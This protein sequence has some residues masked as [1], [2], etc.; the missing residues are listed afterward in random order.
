M[1]E[2]P[3]A[4]GDLDLAPPG[5]LPVSPGV[6]P[7]SPSMPPAWNSSPPVPDKVTPARWGQLEPRSDVVPASAVVSVADARSRDNA[8]SP[9]PEPKLGSSPGAPP[10]PRPIR[11]E[12]NAPA[13]LA[14]RPRWDPATATALPPQDAG[15]SS[16]WVSQLA[17]TPSPP[18]TSEVAADR[19]KPTPREAVPAGRDSVVSRFVRRVRGAGRAFLEP[20]LLR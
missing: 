19:V 15:G 13:S 16:S 4:P 7:S 9:P 10:R 2:L 14:G 3:S 18:S 11:L 17:L 5:Q 12:S 6:A 20:Q 8:A 1:S